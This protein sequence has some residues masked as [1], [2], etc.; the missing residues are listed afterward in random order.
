MPVEQRLPWHPVA[1]GL[2]GQAIHC[3]VCLL[4]ARTFPVHCCPSCPSWCGSCVLHCSAAPTRVRQPHMFS[5]VRPCPCPMHPSPRGLRVSAQWCLPHMRWASHGPVATLVAGNPRPCRVHG[6]PAGR[7]LGRTPQL[8]MAHSACA[9]LGARVGV[10]AV[11]SPDCNVALL[12]LGWCQRHVAAVWLVA[13]VRW[14]C[15]V[16]GV[17]CTALL[18][19]EGLPLRGHHTGLSKP[20]S[21]GPMRVQPLAWQCTATTAGLDAVSHKS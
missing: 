16:V 14:G 19:A 17:C 5:L 21:W 8:L 3:V 12:L 6:L 10:C 13:S 20:Q 7:P 2:A 9:T 11:R 15:D 4:F 1:T 18:A